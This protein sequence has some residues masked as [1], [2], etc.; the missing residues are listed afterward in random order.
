MKIYIDNYNPKSF[1][2]EKFNEL[3]IRENICGEI[4]SE[5]GI[6]Q[7]TKNQIIQFDIEDKPLDKIVLSDITLIADNS[8]IKKKSVNHIP[9]DHIFI[10][11]HEFYY[12][13]KTNPCIFVLKCLESNKH[14]FITNTDVLHQ[15]DCYFEID[16]YHMDNIKEYLNEFLLKIK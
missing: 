11:I 4:Y 10:K 5:D 16:N 9:P 1:S 8:I 15:F 7:V 13:Y 2:R 3:L 12:K 14:D 6:Y